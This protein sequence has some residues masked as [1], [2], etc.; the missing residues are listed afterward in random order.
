MTPNPD[1]LYELL[2]AVHRMRDA[3]AGEPLRALLQ[4]IAEQVDVVQADIEGLYENWFIETCDDWVV[5]YLGDLV[6]EALLTPLGDLGAPES[7]E[8][9]RRLRAASP[10]RQVAGAIGRR[11]RKGTPAVLEE[12]TA[13]LVG[14]PARVVESFRLLHYSQPLNHL[15]L[16]RGS[17]VDFSNMAALDQLD[18]PFDE[19]ARTIDFARIGSRHT[20]SRWSIPAVAVFAWRLRPQSRTHAEAFCIDRT[21]NRYTFS[22]LGNDAPLVA[23]ALAEPD[24]SHIAQEPNLPV[25]ITRRALHDRTPELY[26]PGRSLRI[27]RDGLDHAVPVHDI[28]AA[29]LSEWAYRPTANEVAVDPQ[30]GRMVFSSRNEPENGVW[31]SFNEGFPDDLGGGEY[32]RE[33]SPIDDRKYYSVGSGG[34]HARI[35]DAVAAFVADRGAGG[36]AA[37]AVIEI[38]D[39]E[40]YQ[41][42][43]EIELAPGERLELRAAEGFR[44]VIRLLDLY[45]N[46]PDQM[47]VRGLAPPDDAPD[48]PCGPTP[49]RLVLDGLVITGRSVEVVGPVGSLIV[50]HCTLVPGWSLEH[51]CRPVHGSEASIELNDT[52]AGLRVDRSIIGSIKVEVSEVAVEPLDICLTDSVLDAT[53]TD[54]DAVSGTDA[55]HAHAQVTAVRTTVLGRV[56]THAVVLGEDSIFQGEMNVARRQV[57]CLR[58]CS[59]PAGSRTPRRYRCQPDLARAAAVERAAAAGLSASE[60]DRLIAEETLRVEPLFDSVHYGRPDYARLAL[61]CAPEI[62]RGADDAGELGVYHDLFQPQRADALSRALDEFTPAGMAAGIFFAT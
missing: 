3:Q 61:R 48:E 29:D 4:V 55:L 38:V 25:F 46:R 15:H 45:A 7:A 11:R 9:L 44:P 57:G 36:T 24:V 60:Q 37:D 18:G 31:V 13:D 28:V 42:R 52:T 16:D 30:L 17:T 59:V 53:G 5:P 41:E 22:V 50:R 27:W 1:R 58:Y 54:V 12:L 8:A 51:D 62:V 21:R 35:M 49:P 43:I 33:V 32:P 34:Q 47:R 56:V 26:G 14:W 23:N 20:R 2:P 19:M 10:R 39:G 6:G 40:V